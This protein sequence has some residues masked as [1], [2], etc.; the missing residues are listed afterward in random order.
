[1]VSVFVSG[2]TGFVATH[3]IRELI[4]NDYTVV[5]SV[6]NV[7]KGEKLKEHFPKGFSYEV[8]PDLAAEG[9]FDEAVK[10][11]PEVTVFLHTASPLFFNT[12][13][14]ERDLLIPAINGTKGALKA[15][16][17]YGP[18]ITRVVYTSSFA[19]VANFEDSYN[20][21]LTVDE[22][23]WNPIT[24]E[25]S[26]GK[27]IPPALA[28]LFAYYGSKTVAER[29]AW[30]FV[31]EEKPNFVLSLVNPTYIFGPQEIDED[32]KGE[33]NASA[34]IVK[35]LL[36]SLDEKEVQNYSG[37]SVDVRDIAKAHIVAF[38]K[39]EAKNKRLLVNQEYFSTQGILN[40]LHE[41]FPQATNNAPVG[42]PSQDASDKNKLV[43]IDCS[44]TR[45]ILGFDLIPLEKSIIDAVDQILS[46][47]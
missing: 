27:D 37:G 2:A 32:A 25:Q 23:S 14:V 18:Q 40:I 28:A 16:K 42:N 46:V 21:S 17:E 29:A 22:R 5:G 45:N 15:I 11:H 33:L 6:R 26:C 36:E 20:P 19:A 41:K 8:V 47:Q 30:D 4:S 39:D 13:D 24:Y 31:E 44:S 38:E 7:E 10:K 3:V 34:Q 9:A 12:T 43:K 35:G 1:M